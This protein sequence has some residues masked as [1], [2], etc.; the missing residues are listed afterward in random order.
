MLARTR[1]SQSSVYSL[2]QF[3]I[4]LFQTTTIW[5]AIL[6]E[7]LSCVDKLT[8]FCVLDEALFSET[9]QENFANRRAEDECVWVI[10]FGDLCDVLVR[11]GVIDLVQRDDC[12]ELLVH[13][14]VHDLFHC[15]I[16]PVF[17]RLF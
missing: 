5:L 6:D 7:I 3:F 10:L 1:T 12:R 16:T 14:C 15:L 4:Q 11:V 13:K 17:Q 2:L 9:S 8:A